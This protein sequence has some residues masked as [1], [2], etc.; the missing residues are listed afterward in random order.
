MKLQY[1][2][3]LFDNLMLHQWA[4]LKSEEDK[5]RL[6]KFFTDCLENFEST[7]M[8]F[9][10]CAGLAKL[11][12]GGIMLNNTTTTVFSRL[13][14]MFFKEF[15]QVKEYQAMILDVFIETFGYLT[16]IKASD[17]DEDR[18]VSI[19]QIGQRFVDWTNP[20]YVE[21]GKGDPAIHVQMA[22]EIVRELSRPEHVQ[23]KDDRRV[24]FQLFQYLYLPETV[25]DDKIKELK[26]MMDTLKA[27]RPPRDSTSKRVFAKFEASVTKMYEAQL[28]D[29][30]DEDWKNMQEHKKI[31]DFV[32]SI[33]PEDEDEG[34]E[35]PKK[36]RKRRSPSIAST[37]TD[38]DEKTR[39]YLT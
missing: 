34:D 3:I 22:I 25:D 39:V 6:I 21:N 4:I 33:I 36:G 10:I 29:F 24:L 38:G 15:R 5:N 14:E 35:Q 37:T 16:N 28:H 11:A 20:F 26:V 30:N 8:R 19:L 2:R 18:M 12:H 23:E 1:L 17:D 7:D 9:T 27:R 13:W 31:L 32:D